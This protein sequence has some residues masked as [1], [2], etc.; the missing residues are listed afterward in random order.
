MS[1]I[2]KECANHLAC[3]LTDIAKKQGKLNVKTYE[4]FYLIYIFRSFM[5][6]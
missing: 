2:V 6:Y 4:L 5:S 3:K 1:V